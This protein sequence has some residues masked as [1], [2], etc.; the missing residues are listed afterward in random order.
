M[1]TVQAAFDWDWEAADASFERALALN[2]GSARIRRDHAG[3]LSAMGRPDEAVAEIERALVL[4]P[5]SLITRAEYG[6]ILF[7]REAL[8]RGRSRARGRARAGS[9]FLP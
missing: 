3:F 9:D 6:W 8:R 1:A 4:D 7:F 5:V 2:P